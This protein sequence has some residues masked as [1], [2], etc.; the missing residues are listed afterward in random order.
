L[1]TIK[2]WITKSLL[3]MKY[4]RRYNES[5]NKHQGDVYN[6]DDTSFFYHKS[7]P[8]FRNLIE[9]EGLKPM[10][11]DSYSIHSPEDSA[12]PA[13]FM[14]F[15]D[16][17]YYDST[18]DDDIWKVSCKGLDNKIYIDNEVGTSAVITYEAIPRSN[19]ELVYKGTGKA[20]D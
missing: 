11:G 3:N 4:L 1:I 8:M 16:M 12:T 20:I 15:G 5:F 2:R 6:Y 13:I 17:D 18:Y 19:M 9:K 14:Y 10:K 7:N